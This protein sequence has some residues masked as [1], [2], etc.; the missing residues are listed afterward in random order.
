[1]ISGAKYFPSSSLGVLNTV[2]YIKIL[3]YITIKEKIFCITL[4]S[5]ILDLK[6]LFNRLL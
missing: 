4:Y 3:K 5:H 6:V 1:M 2:V